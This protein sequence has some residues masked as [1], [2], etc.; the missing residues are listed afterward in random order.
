MEQVKGLRY[1]RTLFVGLG[2]AGA[3]TLRTL[4]KKILAANSGELPKQIKFLLIDTNATELSNYRDFDSSEKICIAVREPYQRYK[5]DLGSATHEFIPPQNTA[6]LQALERGAGQIR[7]NGHFAV[8]ENQYSNKL[9]RIFRETADQ[10]EDIDIDGKRLE[11]DPKV[12]VRLVFSIA[13]GTGSG[14][15]L[16]IATLLRSAIKHSEL[17]AYIYSATH[18]SK[19]V[20]NSAKYAVMQNA[21]TALCELDYMMHFGRDKRR[22]DIRFNF[23]P[24]VTQSIVQTNKPFEEVYYIDKHTSYPAADSVEFSYNEISRLQENTAEVMHI[25]A[26][27]IITAHT[28]TVD[29]VR[30]KIM[31]GQ[32]DVSDKFAWVSGVGIAE[33]F[34]NKL[35]INNPQVV[36]ACYNAV[37]ARV[38]SEGKQK[39]LDYEDEDKIAQSLISLRYDESKGPLDK[40]P[41]LKKFGNQEMLKTECDEVIDKI[42]DDTRLVSELNYTIDDILVKK[43]RK[44]DEI[45]K[46]VVDAFGNEL[47]ILIRKL[48]DDD[49]DYKNDKVKGYDSK[50]GGMSLKIVRTILKRVDAKLDASV[51][52]IT[53]EQNDHKSLFDN[54]EKRLNVLISQINVAPGG[55][56]GQGQIGNGGNAVVGLS[57]QIRTAQKKGL[58]NLVLSQRDGKTLDVLNGCKEKVDEAITMLNDWEHILNDANSFGQTK[59]NP[60]NSQSD[61]VIA[62]SNRVEV[63]MV[64]CE[65]GLRLKY[66]NIREVVARSQSGEYQSNR[67]KFDAICRLLVKEAGSLHKYLVKGIEK[68][69][70][71][72]EDGRVRVERTEC[73]QKI[74][75]LIDL[76]TPT[77]Q[78]D[79]H[80]Y[81][82]RVKEDHFWYIMT[83]CPEANVAEKPRTTGK[84]EDRNKSVGR[85]LKDLIEQNTLDAKINLV[86]VPGWNDKAIVYRVDS[87]IPAYFVEGVCV[88]TNNDNSLNGCEDGYTLEGCY[89]ELKKTRQSYTPFS[90]EKLREIL[91]N[92]ICALKPLDE[93][94]N[95]KVLD[96]WLNFLILNYIR[97]DRVDGTYCIESPVCGQRLTDQLECRKN[98]LILGTTRSEAFETFQRYCGEL[99]K[100]KKDY[101]DAI[102][103][104]VPMS[105]SDK[106][107]KN[108]NAIHSCDYIAN[109]YLCKYK[110]TD[111]E[112]LTKEDDDFKLLDREM[113]Q[114]DK[115]FEVYDKMKKEK[116]RNERLSGCDDSALKEYCKK[117]K[118]Q[119]QETK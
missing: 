2:G 56:N 102:K 14:V 11:R 117:L 6:F 13:G 16:P 111:I 66:E 12:E 48:I 93:I 46:D 36:E 39:D 88:S 55:Q 18:Y 109:E 47:D 83:D 28:G 101:Q 76:S 89:E 71:L 116:E 95:D 65:N 74:D 49:K 59:K 41:I 23:G 17:T 31:E 29:N 97:V 90:H 20:E 112:K 19:Q 81:G 26:T 43:D 38:D 30:Q 33:L 5:H 10:L 44:S 4:K 7:S 104:P 84:E 91:E 99:L 58:Y 79:T 22:E 118:E 107:G 86:H 51:K 67:D 82:D 73:Q 77:M 54:E 78:V 106:K 45:I 98:I 27:N 1:K 9:R 53:G 100:E 64:D 115:R 119:K 24:E 113:K 37:D 108:I 63:H 96:L 114:L 32:F 110:E 3:R 61:N 92:K 42:L 57:A 69:K 8:I 72:S 87:A 105:E 80:G 15:F 34:F 70:N 35:D 60:S 25:S 68:I 52:K 94:E 62:K 103:K 50:G 85:L 21:Y 40:D 75:R